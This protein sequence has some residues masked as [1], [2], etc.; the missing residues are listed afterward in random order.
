MIPTEAETKRIVLDRLR[1]FA[2]EGNVPVRIESLQGSLCGFDG[3]RVN[4]CVSLGR[5]IL[6]HYLDT[7]VAEGLLHREG[8]TLAWRLA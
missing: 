8:K 7:M 6:R 3:G 1:G 4:G 2:G 5:P